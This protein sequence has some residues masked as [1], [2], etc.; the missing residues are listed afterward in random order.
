MV[1]WEERKDWRAGAW[2]WWNREVLD[3]CL[4]D[5]IWLVVA[6]E[7]GSTVL[8]HPNVLIVVNGSVLVISWKRSRDVASSWGKSINESSSRTSS[9]KW[10]GDVRESCLWLRSRHSKLQTMVESDGCASCK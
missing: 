6:V 4:D 8:A 10:W 2:C 9:V 7:V 3:P 1:S 5:K